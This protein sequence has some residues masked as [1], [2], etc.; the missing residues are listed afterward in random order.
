LSLPGCDRA[1]QEKVKNMDKILFG[2]ITIIILAV[3][4]YFAYCDISMA[5]A[6]DF[7]NWR[8]FLFRLGV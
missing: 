8:I 4:L 1:I 6:S 3:I 7:L 5:F 2:I